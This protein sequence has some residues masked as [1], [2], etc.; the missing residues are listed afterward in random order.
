[1][2]NYIINLRRIFIIGIFAL[3]FVSCSDLMD[4]NPLDQVASETFWTSEKE[5]LMALT[6]V[7]QNLQRNPF[8]HDDAKSDVMAGE[9]SA[10]QSQSWVPLAQGQIVSTSGSLVDEIYINCY[11]LGIQIFLV[12]I[13]VS[14]IF[15]VTIKKQQE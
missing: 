2:N 7:Y 13:I 14:G 11:Q 4:K 5:V 10:N 12:M 8:R 15:L 1:M 6:G 3:F 9:S